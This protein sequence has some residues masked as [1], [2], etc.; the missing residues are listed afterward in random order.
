MTNNSTS[1]SNE[2]KPSGKNLAS[3]TD[4]LKSGIQADAKAIREVTQSELEQHRSHLQSLSKSVADTTLGDIKSQ[5]ALALSETVG[6]MKASAA[7]VQET[8]QAEGKK[9]SAN[10]QA[11]NKG[12]SQSAKNI[13]N[14]LKENEALIRKQAEQ[15]REIEAHSQTKAWQALKIKCWAAIGATVA[16]CGAML[17]LAVFMVPW[18]FWGEPTTVAIE[19]E[20]DH[21]VLI[22][23]DWKICTLSNGSKHP[24]KPL[25][26]K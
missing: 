10:L 9:F 26:S 5:A 15:I 23:P 17:L 1:N 11:A 6:T 25:G 18:D 20:K 21:V 7:Q 8:Y 3:L 19:D 14:T 16:L 24:C 12:F 13:Q 2:S 22:G 4:R